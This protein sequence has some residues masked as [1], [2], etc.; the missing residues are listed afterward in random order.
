MILLIAFA[1]LAGVVTVLSPCILPLLPIILSSTADASG[2]KRPLG[3]VIGFVGSFTFFTLFLTTI[4]RLSGIPAD[5]L[6]VLSIVVLTVFGLSLLVPRVQILI[7]QMFSKLS[8]LLP[9]R[10]KKTGFLGGLVIGLSLGLLW[11]PCVGP[12]LASVISLAFTGEVNSQAVLITLSYSTGTASPMFLIMQAGS[13][14][15]QKV[16]WLT[17]NSAKIQKFFGVLMIMTAVGIFFNVDRRFQTF[18]LETFPNYGA[19]LTRFEDNELVKRELENM[20]EEPMDEKTIGK[21]MNIVLEDMGKAPELIPGG[22]WF[23]SSPITLAELRGKVVLIDFWTYTCINCIRTFPYLRAWHEKYAPEGL[24]II[25]VHTPEF[26][27][28]KIPENVQKAI[29]DYQLKYPIMQ[30]NNYET[31]RAYKNRYWP[32]EYLIDKEGRVRYTHFGEGKYDVTE[33]AIQ[34]LLAETG[35]SIQQ[36]IANPSYSIDSKTPELYLGYARAQFMQNS[37]QLLQDRK[38]IYQAPAEISPNYFAFDGE[39]QIGL[40]YAMPSAES[41][42]TLNFEAKKVFLVI[43]SSQGESGKAKVY[44]DGEVVRT[45]A[46]EDVKDRLVTVDSDRL[47]ELINLASPGR[48][49]LKLEF[50]DSNLEL[51]AFTFG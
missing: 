4:V 42:L 26:E 21:P 36:E 15:L 30:D 6:R 9:N 13:T 16:P 18:I 35:K 20:N 37:E 29:E 50:L 49:I 8:S 7:E 27:F 38:K 43:K 25:G 14:A 3:V 22:E 17:R 10:Q 31:W 12:I 28:E 34:M 41:T 39:W 24:V 51:Y 11:A 33:G 45:S 1:F 32:A 19:G 48:H 5:S 2:K 40:E 46:G 44:L 47:Y 23:N